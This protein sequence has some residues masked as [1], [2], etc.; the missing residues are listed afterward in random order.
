MAFHQ[1]ADVV[2]SGGGKLRYHGDFDW[3]GLAI[4]SSVMRRHDAKPWRMNARD[5]VAGVRLHAEHVLLSGTP[6]PTPWD[7]ELSKAMAA[8]GRVLFEESV[9]DDL[10]GD[11][12]EYRT[13]E[14]PMAQHPGLGSHL[15]SFGI[16][17]RTSGIP[18]PRCP[19]PLSLRVART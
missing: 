6:Q 4:A 19:G 13:Y 17:S 12:S 14:A 7:P 9:A 3:P 5:Y 2:V 1:L 18:G 10:V 11:L 16:I 15:S 8:T